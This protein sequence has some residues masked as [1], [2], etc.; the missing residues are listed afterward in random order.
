MRLFWTHGYEGTTL[1]MLRAATGLTAP[2]IYNAFTDK[3]TLFTRALDR[4]LDRET[5]FAVEALS[6]DVP[7][8]EAMRRL[9]HGAAEAYTSEGKPSGCLFVS[10]G[11]TEVPADPTVAADLA[12]RRAGTR[13]AIAERLARAPMVELPPYTEP[14]ILAGY[15]AG[16]LHGMAVRARDGA[17]RDDLVSHAEMALAGWTAG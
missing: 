4:Y 6:A 12:R 11:L 10:G 2:Q 7:A 13:A 1:A 5:A 17:G 8:R 15:I 3:R 14:D 16:T 9:L